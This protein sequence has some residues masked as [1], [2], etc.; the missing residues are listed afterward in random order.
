MSRECDQLWDGLKGLPAQETVAIFMNDMSQ[1][2]AVIQGFVHLLRM[3]AET[4]PEL[5]STFNEYL[6]IIDSEVKKFVELR[7]CLVDG[8]RE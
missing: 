6:N 3:D 1:P 8:F 7:N 2:I 4:V 5:P